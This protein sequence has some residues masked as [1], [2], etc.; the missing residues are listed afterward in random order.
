MRSRTPPLKCDSNPVFCAAARAAMIERH[1]KKRF[2]RFGG[3]NPAVL[4]ARARFFFPTTPA[5]KGIPALRAGGAHSLAGRK[6]RSVVGLFIFFDVRNQT[7]FFN[8]A[9]QRAATRRSPTTTAT[10]AM[11]HSPA[12][13]LPPA[14]LRPPGPRAPTSRRTAAPPLHRHRAAPPR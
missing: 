14:A 10:G 5:K 3:K 1:L 4:M 8:A 2:S 7:P 11:P 12:A 13:A 9:A 6:T